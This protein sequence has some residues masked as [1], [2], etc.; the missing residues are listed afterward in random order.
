[1]KI[2]RINLFTKSVIFAA[3]CCGVA[4]ILLLI[5]MKYVNTAGLDITSM[6]SGNVAD[7]IAYLCFQVVS[8]VFGFASVSNAIIGLFFSYFFFVMIVASC[9]ILVAFLIFWLTKNIMKIGG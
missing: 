1:M 9:V 4:I 2:R 3:G 7:K 8:S 5:T 6:A